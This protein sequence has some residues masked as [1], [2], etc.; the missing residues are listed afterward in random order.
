[1]VRKIDFFGHPTTLYY[2]DDLYLKKTIPGG[3]CSIF[4]CFYMIIFITSN[5]HK[6]NNFEAAIIN[7]VSG[8]L[9]LTMEGTVLYADTNMK[10]V[11]QIQNDYLQIANLDDL[12]Q[13]LNITF[14]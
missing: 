10:F 14:Q 1:M 9:N 8:H 7:S 4:I 11:Y 5:L 2:R 6:F 13:Y 12:S 3:L